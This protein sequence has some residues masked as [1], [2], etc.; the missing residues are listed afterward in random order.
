MARPGVSYL[1][2]AQAASKLVA[3]NIRPSI[4]EVRKVL[5]TGSNST[6]NRHLRTWQ[7]KQG[8]Q[9]QA[10]QGLPDTLLIAVK[11]IHDVIR[12]D[13][14]HKI[15]TTKT[16]AQ[17][18]ITVLETQLA[19]ITQRHHQLTQEKHALESSLYQSEEEKKA[20]KSTLTELEHRLDKKSDEN[21]LLQEQINDKKSEINRLIQQLKNAQDNLDHYRESIRE[22][23]EI[24]SARFENT[25]QK[26]DSE[27]QQHRE[28]TSTLK[29]EVAGLFGQMKFL[30]QDKKTYHEE[31]HQS[32]I[33]IVE[34]VSHLQLQ[35][36]KLSELNK[37]HA[38]LLEQNNLLIEAE[39]TD[40]EIIQA[41]KLKLENA[42]GKL[43]MIVDSL[44]KAEDHVANFSHKNMFLVQEKTELAMQLKQLKTTV[45][46]K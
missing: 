44:K 24:E 35:D 9:L 11:G 40:K 2:I 14:E 30:E 17:E 38:I 6:I 43:E 20:L 23:R 12:E 4:E 33:K 16:E 1:D 5:G 15:N 19:D 34:Q 32:Q 45:L 36:E 10:E 41:L 18:A 28:M 42:E 25:I 22:E 13:A 3:Q 39:K 27:V 31:L 29:N 37:N 21:N 8:N 26:L 7:E 46:K